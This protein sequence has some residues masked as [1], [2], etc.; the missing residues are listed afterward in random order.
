VATWDT[1]SKDD[2]RGAWRQ[3]GF[4][5]LYMWYSDGKEAPEI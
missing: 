4:D 5:L 1:I 2:V 3:A